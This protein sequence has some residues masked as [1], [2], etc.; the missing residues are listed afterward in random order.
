MNK[1]QLLSISLAAVL[2]GPVHAHSCSGGDGGGMD[3][4]GNQCNNPDD[5]ALS[6]RPSFHARHEDQDRAPKVSAKSSTPT[7]PSAPA[8]SRIVRAP[9]PASALVTTA[10]VRN[11]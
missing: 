11:D 8:S 10:Q 9:V 4:T 2:V 7:A 1:V 5:V 6:E 3:A